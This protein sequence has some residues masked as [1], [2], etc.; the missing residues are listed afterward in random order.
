MALKGKTSWERRTKVMK[1]FSPNSSCGGTQQSLFFHRSQFILK[2]LALPNF[3]P[4]GYMSASVAFNA[5]VMNIRQ[6]V[7]NYAMV[8]QRRPHAELCPAEDRS[9]PSSP[10]QLLLLAQAGKEGSWQGHN[11]AIHLWSLCLSFSDVQTFF[12]FQR[13]PTQQRFP[14]LAL[15]NHKTV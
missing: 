9:G 15:R 14:G 13:M 5:K 8:K 1:Q 2:V 6:T 12:L 3:I 4:A 7:M 10:H 11:T